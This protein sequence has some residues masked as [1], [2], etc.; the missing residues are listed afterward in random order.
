MTGLPAPTVYHRW[1]GWHAPA[2]R[3]AL[4]AFAAGVIVAVVLLPFVTW[5]M[6]LVAGWDAVSL[7]VLLATWPVILRADGSL[8]A[9]SVNLISGLF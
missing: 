3:R 2:M 6:A 9:G 1:L 5:E 7:T 4:T 8:V